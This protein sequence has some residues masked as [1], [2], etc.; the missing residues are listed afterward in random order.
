[1]EY[2]TNVVRSTADDT[3]PLVK[4]VK[5]GPT[6]A[7]KNPAVWTALASEVTCSYQDMAMTAFL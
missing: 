3:A 4:P 7:P 2:D 1:M 5:P 6:N